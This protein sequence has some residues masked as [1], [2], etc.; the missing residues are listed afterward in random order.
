MS[1][2]LVY[3]FK[4]VRRTDCYSEPLHRWGIWLDGAL[5]QR[6]KGCYPEKAGSKPYCICHL[7]IDLSNIFAMLL[8][9]LI[10]ILTMCSHQLSVTR[11]SKAQLQRCY[12]VDGVQECPV[13]KCQTRNIGFPYISK[14]WFGRRWQRLA[15]NDGV[16]V[17]ESEFKKVFAAW[18]WVRCIGTTVGT[19]AV[20]VLSFASLRRIISI[21]T[22]M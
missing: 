5:L 2:Q 10:H 21:V 6:S 9:S 17:E 7:V 18:V 4:Y 22:S 12:R 8:D 16:V 20:V 3:H 13:L 14:L 15:G 19:T 11:L 1:H